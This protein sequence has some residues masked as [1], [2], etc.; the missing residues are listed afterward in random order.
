MPALSHTSGLGR[1]CHVGSLNRD[2]LILSAK[3][4]GVGS[5]NPAID[6]I[7]RCQV[8]DVSYDTF[9]ILQGGVDEKYKHFSLNNWL[10]GLDSGL[11]RSRIPYRS[12]YTEW[13]TQIIID[14]RA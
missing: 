1:S 8:R 4:L 10:A 3:W 2:F 13:G 12:K 5:R 9:S 6:Q 7:I 14:M 11:R